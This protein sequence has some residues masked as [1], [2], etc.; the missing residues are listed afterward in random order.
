MA[1]QPDVSV[2]VCVFTLWGFGCGIVSVSCCYSYLLEDKWKC[3]VFNSPCPFEWETCSYF[4]RKL[5][6]E[7]STGWFHSV[8]PN[9]IL[10]TTYKD[11][12]YLTSLASPLS[13]PLLRS[14]YSRHS[15]L[16]YPGT[17]FSS[18]NLPCF[19]HLLGFGACCNIPLKGFLQPLL[20]SLCS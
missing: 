1:N 20:C 19:A 8:R 6:I 3:L 9:W 17:I 12:H 11:P 18:L 13:I 14:T 10:S 7:F 4:E 15:H 16:P 2:F 5:T